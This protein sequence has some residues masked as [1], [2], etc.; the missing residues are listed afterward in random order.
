MQT[1]VGAIKAAESKPKG[2]RIA[3]AAREAVVAKQALVKA[4]GEKWPGGPNRYKGKT[5]KELIDATGDMQEHVKTLHK[6]AKGI[7]LQRENKKTGQKEIY[8]VPPS[9]RA[10]EI[11]FDRRFGKVQAPVVE[12]DPNEVLPVAV[13]PIQLVVVRQKT[14]EV[15][16]KVGSDAVVVP[17]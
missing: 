4:R 14:E 13:I 1:R 11:L 12:R 8:E 7:L 15:E 10:L 2:E 9:E 3:P 16:L 6:M 5:I 17:Q